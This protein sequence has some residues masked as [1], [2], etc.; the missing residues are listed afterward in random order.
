MPKLKPLAR[1]VIVITGASSGIGRATA[2]AAAERGASVVLAARG[3]D[4]LKDVASTIARKGG[5]VHVLPT[6][7]GDAAAM[8]RLAQEAVRKFGTI[9]SWVNNAGVSIAGKLEDIPVDDAR[10]LFDTNFWGVVHGS[11]A[12]LPI[13]KKNGGALINI[14]SVTSDVSSP[15]MGIYAASKHAIKGFTDALRIEL[16]MEEAPVSVTLIKPAPVATPVLEHQRN[17]LDRQATMPSPFYQPEDVADAILHAATHPSRDI[18]VGGAA[19]L[20]SAAGRAFPHLSDRVFAALAPKLFRTD[21]APA[22]K[23]DNLHAPSQHAAVHGDPRGHTPRRSL[24]T[25][26]R[27]SPGVTSLIGLG[28]VAAGMLIRGAMRAADAAPQAPSSRRSPT[29]DST[30]PEP[31]GM[32]AAQ[33]DAAHLREEEGGYQ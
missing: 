30:A 5:K 13:L 12:A 24:Y 23:Q 10:R 26:A 4:A 8:E 27:L 25:R 2:L 15:Y 33:E 7:V 11:L 19:H 32:E 28:A 9:D 3:E 6:D 29:A 20:G 21:H 1:Q 17:Y 14:G 22:E 18:F 31:A 16:E